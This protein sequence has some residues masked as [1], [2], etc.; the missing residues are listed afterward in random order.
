MP[1]QVD[2]TSPR[3]TRTS[4]KS[5]RVARMKSMSSSLERGREVAC[6]EVRGEKG[7]MRAEVGKDRALE[8]GWVG[9]QGMVTCES[10]KV[11]G[12]KCTV[13]GERDEIACWDAAHS[14]ALL[15]QASWGS[16]QSTPCS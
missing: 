5:L 10:W 9:G 4:R 8:G 15:H 16:Q 13:S 3:D 2:S 11:G 7:G 12:A 1:H 14:S 6:K